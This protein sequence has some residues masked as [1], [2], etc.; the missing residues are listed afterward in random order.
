MSLRPSSLF[1][2]KVKQPLNVRK[3]KE[4][5]SKDKTPIIISNPIKKSEKE[6][7]RQRKFINC[8]W[9]MNARGVLVK[10]DE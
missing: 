3:N 4:S 9:R 8:Q 7:E 10:C 5:K 6:K 1:L 2:S